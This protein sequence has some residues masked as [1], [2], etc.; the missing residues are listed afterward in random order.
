MERKHRLFV[1]YF[2]WITNGTTKLKII[3]LRKHFLQFLQWLVNVLWR[4]WTQLMTARIKPNHNV[5]VFYST[6]CIKLFVK[7]MVF[8]YVLD[9]KTKVLKLLFLKWIVFI[10]CLRYQCFAHPY[11]V[12][13]QDII[14]NND[15]RIW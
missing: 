7:V 12:N 2:I 14:S 13:H 1:S 4:T 6:K 11:Y 3:T 10:L 15:K 8:W 5:T 9:L